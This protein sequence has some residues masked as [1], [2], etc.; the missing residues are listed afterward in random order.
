FNSSLLLDNA[1]FCL[2]QNIAVPDSLLSKLDNLKK[3]PARERG[4]LIYKEGVYQRQLG[5]EMI[6]IRLNRVIFKN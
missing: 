3:L 6:Q 1:Y 2:G 4:P 5:T